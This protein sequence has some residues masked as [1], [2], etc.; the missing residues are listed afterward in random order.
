M[1]L[2]GNYVFDALRELVWNAL[3]DPK[4][5]GSVMPGG[6]A[7]ERVADNQFAGVLTVKVGPVQGTFQAQIKLS[8]VKPPE[9]YRIEVDG[10]GAP[11]FVKATGNIRLEPR[12]GQTYMEYA[13][14]AQIGGRIASVGQRLLDATARSLIRQGLDALNEYLKA[15]VASQAQQRAQETAAVAAKAAASAAAAVAEAQAP[16]IP[17]PVTFQSQMPAA[18]VPAYQ[19]PSQSRLAFNVTRDVLNDLVP[20]RYRPVLAGAAFGLALLLI[21]RISRR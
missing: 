5:L 11:G 13:G 1:E 4:V 16:P 18:P 12:D 10:R 20:A 17:P 8:D 3:Q 6:Q 7:F 19:P 2:S 21:W 9:S 14:Q 15:Q